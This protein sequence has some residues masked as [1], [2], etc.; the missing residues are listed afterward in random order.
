[1]RLFANYLEVEK[2]IFLIRDRLKVLEGL[3][4]ISI[5]ERKKLTQSVFGPRKR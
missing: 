4:G 2:R 3:N 5:I 1:M